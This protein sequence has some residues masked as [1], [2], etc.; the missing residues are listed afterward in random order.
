MAM[1]S[2]GIGSGLDVNSIVTQLVAIEKRPLQPLQAKATTLQSQLSLYGTIKS[3]ASALGDAAATLATASHWSSQV[4]SSSNASAVGV[5]AGAS[6]SAQSL[7]VEVSQLARAQSAA[8]TGVA[9]GTAVGA[10]GTLTLQL[11]KWA[12]ASTALG[13]TPGSSAAVDISVAATD[14]MSAIAAKINAASAGVTAS[15]LRDGTNERLVVRSTTSGA[16]TGFSITTA[17]DAGLSMFALTGTIDSTNAA[18]ASGMFLSQTS[19]DAKA[20]INGVEITS[21]SN[22]LTNA[23]TGVNLQL[24]QV[25]TSPVEISLSTD[26]N[27]ITKNI[28]SFVDAYNALNQTLADATKYDAASKK[29]GLLQGDSVTV[30]L[31]TT[32]RSILGSS[33]V[34][35]S[36]SRLS[37]IGLERQTDGSLKINTTRLTTA[38]TDMSNLKALFTTN[39]S[40][41]QTNGFGMKLRDFAYGLVASDGRVTSK[42]KA[43]QGA[44]TRNSDDQDKVTAR[45][46]RV[47]ANLRS[48]YTALDAQMSQ[49]NGLSSYVTAQLAQWNK[50]SA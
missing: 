21:S 3:Q 19:L 50:S 30:G 33:S 37:D 4:A 18:P 9:A 1:S 47:E 44:I 14:T 27:A 17:G 13:F 23:V 29:S 32:L 38:T 36:F 24:S 43:L 46:T 25:T 20:K 31:Q 11:G 16:E 26:T 12:G 5:S 49:I 39:N 40:D 15:V 48:Q 34:G 28:Q 6:A 42:S 35:S 41:T 45:A 7:S 8:S 2:Q 22:T 10:T